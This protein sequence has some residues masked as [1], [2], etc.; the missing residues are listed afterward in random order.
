MFHYRLAPSNNRS[1]ILIAAFLAI[2]VHIGLMNF[3][4]DPEPVF[5]PSVSLPRSV[6]IFLRQSS[7]VQPPD[8]P[9]DKI[10]NSNPIK[11]EHLKAEKEPEMPVLQKAPAE[12]I[13]SESS[14]QPPTIFEKK[15]EQ[16]AALEEEKSRPAV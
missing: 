7:I 13:E 12:I 10:Q 1:R 4:F 6:S 8:Q 2:A 11:E 16:P 15:V 5:V 3:E 14:F 9:V